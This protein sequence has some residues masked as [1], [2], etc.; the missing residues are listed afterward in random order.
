MGRVIHSVS[1]AEEF[2]VDARECGSLQKESLAVKQSG[3]E[4]ALIRKKIKIFLVYKEIQSGAVAKSYTRKSFLIYEEIGKY[5]PIYE[6]AV[7]HIKL[8]N[9]S[10][11]NFLICEGNLIFFFISVANEDQ[12]TPEVDGVDRQVLHY[13]VGEVESRETRARI[14]KLLRSPRI[15]SKESIPPAL[16]AWRAG[17]T[18][19]LLL[20][21]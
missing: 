16:V 15:D 10:I 21:S 8:C 2:I 19:L 14:V 1:V 7:S 13:L 5:F 9:G 6:E 12:A 17:P 4:A 20:S 18:T 11:L 3:R